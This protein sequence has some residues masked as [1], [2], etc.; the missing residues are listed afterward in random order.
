MT[1]PRT[2]DDLGRDKLPPTTTEACG[3]V[4]GYDAHLRRGEYPC[5]DCREANAEKQ[6]AWRA[7]KPG[8][9]VVAA[10]SRAVARATTQLRRAHPTDWHLFLAVERQAAGL[11]PDRR[12][13]SA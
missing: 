2:T 9:A 5:E 3:Y 13:M 10:E 7:T 12:R 6:R 4:R 8:K 11:V 1:G